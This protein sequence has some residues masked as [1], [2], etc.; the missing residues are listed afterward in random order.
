MSGESSR[1]LSLITVPRLLLA[2]TFQMMMMM[3]LV[4]T[5]AMGLQ[6]R[7]RYKIGR[8]KRKV[9]YKLLKGFSVDALD[10]CTWVGVTMRGE[11]N[12]MVNRVRQATRLSCM[13]Q[14]TRYRPRAFPGYELRV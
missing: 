8:Y 4:P 11:A 13:G 1:R 9:W 2:W 14:A 3:I 5:V 12:Q 10:G 6:L 7:N